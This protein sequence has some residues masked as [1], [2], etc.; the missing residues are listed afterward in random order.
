M[1]RERAVHVRQR[2]S[3]AHYVLN[4]QSIIITICHRYHCC[5]P[6][7]RNFGLVLVFSQAALDR[8]SK[9]TQMLKGMLFL[10]AYFFYLPFCFCFWI[11]QQQ[12]MCTFSAKMPFTWQWTKWLWYSQIYS[13]MVS[14]GCFSVT[15][16]RRCGL[17]C[18]MYKQEFRADKCG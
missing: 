11:W 10:C 8:S 5:S 2:C 1:R 13:K 7:R 6:L 16:V 12:A 14:E 3:L 4:E 18:V 17:T 15:A 9:H